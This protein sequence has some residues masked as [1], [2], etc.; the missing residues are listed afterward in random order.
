M[1]R[2][3]DNPQ[4]PKNRD[5]GPRFTFYLIAKI[6]WQ[7]FV[8]VGSLNEPNKEVRIMMSKITLITL[9]LSFDVY[10]QGGLSGSCIGQQN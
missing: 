8:H 10:F 9:F 5:N 4:F 3:P 1:S 2:N 7:Q 6:K